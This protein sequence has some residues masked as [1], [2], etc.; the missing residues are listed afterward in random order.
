MNSLNPA[1]VAKV[2]ARINAS[3]YLGQNHVR[4]MDFGI[5]FSVVQTHIQDIH[6]QAY[7]VVHGGLYAAMIDTAA[8]WSTYASRQEKWGGLITVDL[9]LNFLSNTNTGIVIAKG[10][11]IKMGKSIG[12]AEAKVETEDG[13]LLAHGTSTVLAVLSDHSTDDDLPKKFL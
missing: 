12:Y 8:Y 10:H 5:G 3:P 11:L 9:K 2:L 13:R 7:N 4:V 1:Y 6:I